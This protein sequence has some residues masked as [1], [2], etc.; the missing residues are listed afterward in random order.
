MRA[1]C[2]VSIVLAMCM[3]VALADETA[4][5]PTQPA[6]VTDEVFDA[7]LEKAAS[8]GPGS[9]EFVAAL[10]SVG[11]RFEV[12]QPSSEPGAGAW[13]DVPLNTRGKR[14]DAV[15]FRVP[16]GE[17]R[18]LFWALSFPR[19]MDRW[20]IAPAEGPAGKGFTSFER[21]QPARLFK[22]K[23]PA[24]YAGVVQALSA[25]HL[26]PGREYLIWFVFKD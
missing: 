16:E 10:Q 17:R 6:A 7:A 24:G 12:I 11:P 9:E 3:P 13:R 26:E 4:T 18:D 21:A 20:Y 22:D 15:R 1:C 2:V 14:V 25:E 19:S 23:P 5:Q 8:A